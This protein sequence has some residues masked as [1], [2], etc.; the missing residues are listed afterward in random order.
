[1]VPSAICEGT[2]ALEVLGQALQGAVRGWGPEGPWGC[3][4]P[5]EDPPVPR[6]TLHLLK[7]RQAATTLRTLSLDPPGPRPRARRACAGPRRRTGLAEGP[8]K[9]HVSVEYVLVSAW[10][11]SPS[12]AARGDLFSAA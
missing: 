5:Q 7:Q 6:V 3:C 2:P 9:Q 11:P 4:Q 8:T 10:G 12:C 1:M